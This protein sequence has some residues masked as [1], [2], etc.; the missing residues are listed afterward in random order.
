M[1][2]LNSS[3]IY[4]GMSAGTTIGGQLIGHGA[5]MLMACGA[6]LAGMA[7]V[8]LV[9]T[10]SRGP[11]LV[12]CEATRPD[13]RLPGRAADAAR[14]LRP[15]DHHGSADVSLRRPPVAGRSIRAARAR[16]AFA[17]RRAGSCA[18]HRPGRATAD[19]AGRRAHLRME[20]RH[21]DD[22]PA[23]REFRSGVRESSPGDRR[24]GVSAALTRMPSACSARAT[25]QP[26]PPLLPGPAA[27]STPWRSSGA[28]SRAMTR[29]AARP[30]DSMRT[31]DG[32]WAPLWARSSQSA[33][34][35]AE[36]TGITGGVT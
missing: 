9:V 1:V 10:A 29:P 32:I 20:R 34:C 27:T 21:R 33:A 30:A 23:D 17:V 13:C 16:R 18:P 12:A 15:A 14:G 2:A 8:Y 24:P 36:T 28:N 31:R 26:S 19:L 22:G 5:S 7:L 6:G 4:L 3:C 11:A 35:R 25:T